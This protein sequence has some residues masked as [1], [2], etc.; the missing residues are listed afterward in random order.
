MC[1][2]EPSRHAVRSSL[3]AGCLLF[4]LVPTG[5]AN[6]ELVVAGFASN[7]VHRFELP[8]AGSNGALGQGILQGALGVQVGPDALI[9]VCSELADA[10]LR[11]D[12]AT[13]ALVDEFIADD[14]ATP[15]DETGGLDG[16]SAIVFGPDCRAYVASFNTD[17]VLR[18]DG[19]TGEFL[20]TFV[21]PS[22]GNLNGPDAGMSFGPDGNLYVPGYFNDRIKE[23]DGR[24]GAFLGNFVGPAT[25]EISRP[26]TILFP[27]D[28]HAYIASEGNDRILRVD[29]STGADVVELVVDDPATPGDETGGLDRPTGLAMD[30]QRRLY[31]GS[32]QT[33]SVLRYD[34]DTGAFLDEFVAPGSGGLSLPTALLLRPSAV[35]FCP[36]APNSLGAGCLLAA[37]GSSSVAANALGLTA[38][39]APRSQLGVFFYGQAASA[40]PL[41]DGFRCL[42]GPV[43]RLPPVV[44]DS[45]AQA[46]LDLDLTATRP[47]GTILPGSVWSFQFWYRDP[48]GPG[49]SGSNLSNGLTVDFSQ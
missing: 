14:P 2:Q 38:R 45:R 35:A 5:H 20:G 34:A 49:G 39:C 43:F 8:S 6:D 29:A 27:G 24:T 16:P 1:L 33:S 46:H 31:V 28:G 23:Y 41:G 32:L 9:Y 4:A 44:V 30:S 22:P 25:A 13:G 12:P 47:G 17:S 36:S 26:R 15:E 48:H 37:S 21:A 40:I 10:V 11:F 7:A 42:S 18:Y 3:F 19:R